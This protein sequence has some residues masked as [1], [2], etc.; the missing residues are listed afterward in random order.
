MIDTLLSQERV[1]LQNPIF[2]L[3]LKEDLGLNYRVYNGE[4]G[5]LNVR[6]G[7]GWLQTYNNDVFVSGSDVGSFKSYHRLSDTST[8]GVA[9]SVVSNI[10][11]N[12]IRLN[13]SST[14]DLLIPLQGQ[15]DPTFEF[16]N[17]FT[18]KLI[19]NVSWD[20]RFD[21]N[22]NENI[23]E[24]FVYDTSSFIRLSYFF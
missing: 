9:T 16:I 2:P 18:I 10:K 5:T 15:Q 7:L 21:V 12:K 20:F 11:I 4:Y 6:A 3:T 23:K 24:Y 19:R 22:Y 14:A 8:K 17:I 13:W 1:K